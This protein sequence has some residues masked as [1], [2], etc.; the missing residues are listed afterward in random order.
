M[1]RKVQRIG[2]NSEI[3]RKQK[4]SVKAYKLLKTFPH[5]LYG[6]VVDAQILELNWSCFFI[7]LIISLTLVRIYKN[8]YLWMFCKS[9]LL[10]I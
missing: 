1:W 4:Y 7:N 3:L 2:S 8:R 6:L 10:A 9:T 5:I